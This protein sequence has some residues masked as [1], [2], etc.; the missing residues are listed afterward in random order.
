M[1]DCK[2]KYAEPDANHPTPYCVHC[3]EPYPGESEGGTKFDTLKNR[4]E[5]LPMNEVDEIVQIL[6]LGAAKYG[7]YN[8]MKVRPTDRYLG[9][10]L[11]HIKEW[12]AGKQ[13][14]EESG[15]SPLA[16]AGCNL[17]FLMWLDNNVPGHRDE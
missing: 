12:K 17:L 10:L 14:D 15:L 1:P 13:V 6:T 4:W 7:N 2:H 11:R 8:W 3:K 9:A 16:H 5:L